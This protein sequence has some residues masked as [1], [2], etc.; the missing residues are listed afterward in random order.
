MSKDPVVVIGAGHAAG[1]FA[2]ALRKE[3]YDGAILL[4]GEEAYLPYQRPPLSKDFLAGKMTADR[5]LLRNAAFYEKKDITCQLSSRVDR[6][7][8]KGKTVTVNG[9]EITYEKLVIA[10][11]TRARPLPV[12]GVEAD[13]VYYIRTIGDVEALKARFETAESIAIVGAGFIGLE[14]AAVAATAGKAVTV[15]EAQDRVMPRVV[16]PIVS[17][18]YESYHA[19][20]GV[21]LEME[22]AVTAIESDSGG[23]TGVRLADDRVIAADIVVVGI[24]VIPNTELGVEAGLVCSNGILVDEHACTSDPD[25]YAVGEVALHENRLYGTLRLES[26]QNAQDQAKVAAANIAGRDV[27]YDVVPWFWSNQYNLKLQMTGI[28]TGYDD[29]IIRGDMAEHKFSIIY[30]KDGKMIAVDSINAAADHMASRKLLEAGI[31][32]S[33]D[34][35]LDATLK[36]K[37]HLPR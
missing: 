19:K 12:A 29:I 35:L 6:V 37:E 7:N 25:I 34:D 9:N 21:V 14:V 36:L 30:M 22:A 1:L 26:V 32:P 31:T 18:F 23:V 20:E 24:G 8:P 33:R 3:G 10:T 4:I 27:V 2:E 16:A 13:G 11:G 17:S 5:L 15:I 28:S